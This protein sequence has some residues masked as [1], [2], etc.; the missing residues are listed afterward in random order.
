MSDASSSDNEEDKKGFK[1]VREAVA[2]MA[3]G[4]YEDKD[5]EDNDDNIVGVRLSL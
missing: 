2:E 1:L 5:D 4:T 3:M